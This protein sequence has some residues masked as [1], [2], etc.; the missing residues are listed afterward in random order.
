MQISCHKIN[1]CILHQPPPLQSRKTFTAGLNAHNKH[2]V[3]TVMSVVP[4]VKTHVVSQSL[5]YTLLIEEGP[6][7]HLVT[8]TTYI[9][10]FLHT[11][12]VVLED[13][14]L[15]HTSCSLRSVPQSLDVSVHT[16]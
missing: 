3:V 2:T 13:W 7:E 12:D 9:V 6:H 11:P 4:T 1:L 16:R 5:V 10:R 8:H 14:S 15:N